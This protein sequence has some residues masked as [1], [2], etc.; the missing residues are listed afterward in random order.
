[1][2]NANSLAV[3][4]ATVALLVACSQEEAVSPPLA[5][6]IDTATER[7]KLPGFS[8]DAPKGEVIFSSKSPAVGKHKIDLPQ[9]SLAAHFVDDVVRDGKFVA[10]WTSQV[11]SREEWGRDYLPIYLDSLK[12]VVPGTRVL[13]H[14]VLDTGSW[15]VVIGSERAPVAVGIVTCDPDFQVEITFS[16]YHDAKRQTE[17]TRKMLRSVRCEVTDENRNGLVAATRLPAG[18]G[19]VPSEVGQHFRS[20]DGETLLV[21]FTMGEM[22][23]DTKIYRAVMLAMITNTFDNKVLESGVVDLKPGSHDSVRKVTMSRAHLPT[24]GETLYIGSMYCEQEGA[25]L[26]FMWQAPKV[27]DR[28]AWERLAQVDCPGGESL[29]TPSFESIVKDAC[30]EG[31]RGACEIKDQAYY[32]P[33][34]VPN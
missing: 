33:A 13:H 26:M 12:R 7:L 23:A 14:E 34:G 1:V 16:R 25:S 29:P 28:L 31:N 15:F 6:P 5:K 22:P 24:H 19:Q 30:A 8:M 2:A 32:R 3:V 20:L 27:S 10:S 9:E 11:S 17:L 4:I 18:F 21:N